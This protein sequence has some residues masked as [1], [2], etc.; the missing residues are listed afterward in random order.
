[1]AAISLFRDQFATQFKRAEAHFLV[2]YDVWGAG[3]VFA[4][5]T[6]GTPRAGP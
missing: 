5:T 6:P 1:M 2:S 3:D 4:V